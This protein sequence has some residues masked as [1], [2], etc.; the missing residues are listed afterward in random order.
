MARYPI[1]SQQI[2][3]K[4]VQI[5]RRHHADATARHSLGPLAGN[6]RSGS[7]TRIQR[8]PR[9][10]KTTRATDSRDFDGSCSAD[11]KPRQRGPGRVLSGVGRCPEAA[12]GREASGSPPCMVFNVKL[13]GRPASPRNSS[14]GK[15]P[16]G[17]HRGEQAGVTR[18]GGYRP[19]QATKRPGGKPE[20][21]PRYRVLVHRKVARLWSEL[22]DRVGLESAQQFYDH[23]AQ[24]PGEKPSVGKTT[25]LKGKAAKPSGPGFSRTYHYEISGAG[26]I[27][28]QFNDVY[29]G[30]EG[31]PHPVVR[32]LMIDHS[33]H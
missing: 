8:I 28:Y 27:D 16:R 2:R 22:P 3:Q 17:L 30:A 31:D 10:T 14:G 1:Y 15:R 9:S 4:G 11:Q 12:R 20:Y 33:S 7:P 19:Y 18:L 23:V 29:V 13:A 25:P 26:R 24:T 32:I 6:E 5:E 21:Q